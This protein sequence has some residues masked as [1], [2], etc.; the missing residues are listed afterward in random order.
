MGLKIEETQCRTGIAI[1]MN[2]M[3]HAI[4]NRRTS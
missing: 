3:V 1:R 4:N 2:G